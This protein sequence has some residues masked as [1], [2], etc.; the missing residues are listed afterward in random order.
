MRFAYITWLLIV[1]LH[2]SVY[3]DKGEVVFEKGFYYV[4]DTGIGC[5]VVEWYGGS[6]PYKG[7]VIVGD[8]NSYGFKSVY[9]KSRDTETR[10]YIDDYLLRESDAIEKV[11]KLYR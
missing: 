2:T 4:I 6:I 7:N 8:L 10:L 5:S 3:A 9:N 1:A 11:Y